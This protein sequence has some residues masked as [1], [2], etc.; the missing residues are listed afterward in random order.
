MV[1]RIGELVKKYRD[2]KI[3]TA[4]LAYRTGE[5]Q[6]S[7]KRRLFRYLGKERYLE[8]ARSIGGRT[9]A[10]RLR[11]NPTFREK[12]ARQMGKT[13][14]RSISKRMQNAAFK[15]AWKGKAGRGSKKGIEKLRRLMHASSFRHAWKSKCSLGGQASYARASGI[16]STVNSTARKKW[17]IRGLRHTGRKIIG[18]KGEKMYNDLERRVACI[19]KRLGIAY[20]YEKRF[21]T[22]TRNGFCSIDFFI[23]GNTIIEVTDWDD[24][25]AKSDKLNRKYRKLKTMTPALADFI[26]VTKPRRA[27]EYRSRLEKDIRVLSPKQLTALLAQIAG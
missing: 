7:I 9:M 25:A 16:H 15:A 19:L 3:P 13:V 5:S 6:E 18:P 23:G 14:K 11:T 26:V 21:D 27:E 17:S 20:E 8:A 2:Q 1:Q 12:Y 4:T 24:A 10:E 22:D